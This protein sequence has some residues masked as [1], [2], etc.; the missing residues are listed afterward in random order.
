MGLQ[1]DE[2][3]TEFNTTILVQISDAGDRVSLLQHC[4]V[5]GIHVKTLVEKVLYLESVVV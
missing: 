4:K 5:T 1:L 3:V 2:S